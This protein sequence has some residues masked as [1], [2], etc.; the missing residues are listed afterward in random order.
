MVAVMSFTRRKTRRW[1]MVRYASCD[2]VMGG[3]SKLLAAFEQREEWDEIT[4]FVDLRWSD[5][6]LYQTLGFTVDRTYGP[7][8]CYVI[9]S[10]RV[11]KFNLRKS[12]KRFAKYK[13]SGMTE[14]QMAEAEGIPRIYDAGKLRVI[15]R[16]PI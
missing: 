15:R 11:H 13:G 14:R 9:G 2:L 12:A 1:E 3:A 4:S 8:Y 10:R 6:D 5:G 7:D 16:R